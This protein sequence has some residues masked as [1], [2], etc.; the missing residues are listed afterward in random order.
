MKEVHLDAM[1]LGPNSQDLIV[2][3]FIVIGSMKCGTTA[4]AKKFSEHPDVYIAP[5]KETHFFS[6]DD[7]FAGGLDKYS[8]FFSTHN[9]EHAI[10]ELSPSYSRSKRYPYA[11]E[12]LAEALPDAKI[13]YILR[14]PI[15]RMESQW[16]E[17]RRGGWPVPPFNEA[18]MSDNTDILASSCFWNELSNYRRY[19]SDD[20]ILVI[21]AED[22]RTNPRDLLRRCYEFLNVD[23]DFTNPDAGDIVRQT[24][25]AYV[26]KDWTSRYLR[27]GVGKFVSK[28]V[29]KSLIDV[30]R[31]V[32]RKKVNSRPIWN[33]ATLQ[34]S[35]NQVRPDAEKILEYAGKSADYWE[36]G[37]E[38]LLDES[39]ST[40][41]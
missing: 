41:V 13:I 29:P 35:I 8:S 1:T 28:L 23:P 40:T 10:G 2:A 32:I 11:A 36:L 20:N 3:N 6:E 27:S 19:F 5:I 17:A 18:V 25:G 9:G 15:E 21:F 4:L 24:E 16:I 31:P 33:A 7:I 30:L 26:D 14:N 37:I 34:Y 12:R 38:H 39:H 22:L